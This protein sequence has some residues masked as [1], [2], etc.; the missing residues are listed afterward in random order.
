MGLIEKLVQLWKVSTFF[1]L[2]GYFFKLT[3][4]RGSLQQHRQGQR[5][6]SE[7]GIPVISSA[8]IHPLVEPW[9]ESSLHHRKITVGTHWLWGALFLD[10]CAKGLCLLQNISLRSPLQR[11]T[12]INF[13][14]VLVEVLLYLLPAW[15]PLVRILIPCRDLP[16]P[17][18]L[19]YTWKGCQHSSTLQASQWPLQVGPHQKTSFARS[20]AWPAWLLGHCR[21]LWRKAKCYRIP[22]R[23]LS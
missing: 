23:H 3:Y 7:K 2:Q 10:N 6:M 18:K 8:L 16:S 15:S 11:L 21:F 1:S 9:S 13:S 4:Q 12:C 20:M 19:V 17:S 22:N 14:E 5:Q